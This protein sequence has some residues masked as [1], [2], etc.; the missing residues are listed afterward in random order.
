MSPANTPMM[1]QYLKIKAE[2]TD[3]LLFYR[4]G[5]FYE[6]FFDDAVKGAKLLD[7]NLTHRGYS[8][9]KPIPMAGI[10][11]HAIENYL[12]RLLKKGETIAICEQ[13]GDPATSK[14]PVERKVTRIITPGTLTDEALLDAT[15]DNILLAI[16]STPKGYGVAWVDLSGGRF[17]LAPLADK[18]QLCSLIGRLQPAEI[19]LSENLSFL[20]PRVCTK[21]RPAWEFDV[22]R[23]KQLLCEQFAVKT[24]H[25]MGEE[26]YHHAF[27]AAGALLFYLQTTQRQQLPHLH[28]ITLENDDDYLQLDS[29]TQSHLELFVSSQ[30]ASSHTLL[31][32]IDK[33][34]SAMGSR[35]L[36]RWM[37]KPLRNHVHIKERQA[38]IHE[39][40]GTRQDKRLKP[41]L[42][43][44]GDIERIITR[45]ALRSARPRDLI[46]LRQ[47]LALLPDFQH[48]LSSS[49]ALILVEQLSHLMMQPELY[50][51]LC[52]AIVENPPVLIRDGGVIAPGFDEELDELKAL[53]HDANSKLDGLEAEEKAKSG[54]SSL[55]FGFNRVQGYF[56]ELPKSQAEK[57][58]A[59]YQRKQTLKNVERYVTPELKVFEE[60]VLTAE[61]K[62]LAR[63]KWLYDHLLTELLKFIPALSHIAGALA[64]IDVLANF[65]ER[66]AELNWCCPQ[67]TQDITIDIEDGRHPV[68]EHLVRETFIANPLHLSTE[69]KM[70]LITGPNMGGKSTY[71]RQHALIVLLAHL[72]CFVPA[73]KATIGMVDKLFTRIGASD[74]LSSGRSTFMVE[75]SETAHILRQA[76]PHSLV[77][78]DEI[79]RGTSTFDGMALAYATASHLAKTIRCYTLFSTHF[80]ELTALAEEISVIKNLHLKATINNDDIIFLYHIEQGAANRSYGLEVAKLAGIP[81]EVLQLAY[82]HLKKHEQTAPLLP[83]AK[84]L[85]PPHIESP[86]LKKLALINV[87]EL[88]PKA[89]LD[90][91][92][93]LKKLED[94]AEIM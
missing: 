77:L 9:E 14:G 22:Q 44:I 12:G 90:L 81:H 63:E 30:G 78:I 79:G 40:L 76:T 43:K 46:M 17:H 61:V 70:M 84:T 82:T 87:D 16:H 80:F 39:I 88:T 27:P 1:Q 7:L 29:A 86:I 41:L 28:Q 54:L 71:M 38:A 5:D 94:E 62:A 23:A 72:G 35:L 89:A 69:S 31:S 4:M 65:A 60:K 51:L 59:H 37:T 42:Q 74:D 53:S 13:I 64:T 52:Q 68:I 73:S 85:A 24:L 48:E 93:H 32:I 6:L 57:A 2:H 18:S 34:H 26:T 20:E 25:G 75:M 8:A 67:L 11:Y 21:L 91:I 66:A 56:I 33:T 36:K 83:L 58:P 92:Y 15:L 19:L 3:K 45:I 49:Q 47:T 55:K 10:P 50:N